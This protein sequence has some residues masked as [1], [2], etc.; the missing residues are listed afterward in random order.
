MEASIAHGLS[1]LDPIDLQGG[2]QEALANLIATYFGED[3]ETFEG[4]S[5]AN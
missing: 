3:N 5:R 1:G 2:D 4:R